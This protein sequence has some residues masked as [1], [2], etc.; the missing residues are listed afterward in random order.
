MWRLLWPWASEIAYT[1]EYTNFLI[2]D[3]GDLLPSSYNVNFIR[4]VL[5]GDEL[6]VG[7]K[8]TAMHN[9]NFVVGVTT[10]NQHGEK[11]LEGT[12]EVAQP[13][14]V[15]A[16]TG[17]VSQEQGMGIVPSGPLPTHT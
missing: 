11:V 7:I 3:D 14:T 4:M 8:H 17:Q 12:A 9:G 15:Y 5:P 13:P 16:F 2:E 1:R 6:T 10:I